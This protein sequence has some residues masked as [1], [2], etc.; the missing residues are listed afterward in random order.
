[1]SVV[2]ERQLSPSN[3]RH[4]TLT[5]SELPHCAKNTGKVPKSPQAISMSVTMKTLEKLTC[6]CFHRLCNTAHATSQ[7]TTV[8]VVLPLKGPAGL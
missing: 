4:W 2:E 8:A 5:T 6:W 1:M 3:R 7:T